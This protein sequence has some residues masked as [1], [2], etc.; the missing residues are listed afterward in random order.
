MSSIGPQNVLKTSYKNIFKTYSRH[1][2]HVLHRYLQDVFKTY[3]QVKL[4]LLARLREVFNTF[5]RGSFPKTVIYRGICP[6]Y[7][8][9]EKFT[10]SV[11]SLQFEK[12]IKISQVLDF[13]F[14]TPFSDY[15]QGHIYLNVW[16]PG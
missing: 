12:E 7:T 4:L 3:H 13:H 9:S 14:T 6:G 2:Q 15:L 10:V 16:L 11:E 5:L 1:F 8:T